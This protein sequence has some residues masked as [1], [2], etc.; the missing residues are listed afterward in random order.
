VLELQLGRTVTAG[1]AQAV[2]PAEAGAAGQH[3]H[4]ALA[5]ETGQAVGEALDDL[6]LVAAH[7][8]EVDLGRAEV[9]S[10][11]VRRLV[12]HLGDVQQRLGRDAADVEAHAAQALLALDERDL[13]AEIGGAEGRAVAAGA[14]AD[15][16]QLRADGF[17]HG[18]LR[19]CVR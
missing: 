13:E 4:L 1:H 10:R 11:R 17:G 18:V 15:H 7:A 9:E 5:G 8:V 16:D 14:G 6:V 3:A 19:A 2:R 12:D